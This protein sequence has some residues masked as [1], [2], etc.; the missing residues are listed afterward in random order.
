MRA[1]GHANRYEHHDDGCR[2]GD[3]QFP[4][5]RSSAFLVGGADTLQQPGFE[6]GA[7]FGC[8]VI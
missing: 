4:R 1:V 7:R 8:A 2:G 5:L 6:A 3:P